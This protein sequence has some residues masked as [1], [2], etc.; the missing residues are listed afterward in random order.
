MD[1]GATAVAATHSTARHE[2]LHAYQMAEDAFAIGNL[3]ESVKF[4][5]QALQQAPTFAPAH[6]LLS[7]IAFSGQLRLAVR[8]LL[9]AS[10]HATRQPAT[11]IA[12]I[13]LRLI[14][15][16]E[17]GAAL[18][19]INDMDT[20]SIQE[21]SVLF[22][23]A[24]QL[25]LLEQHGVALQFL[26]E[27]ESR[28]GETFLTA[29]FRGNAMKFMGRMD[30]AER[31]F[32]RSIALK[33]E[34]CHSH[35]ALAFLGRVAGAARRANRIQALITGG[36]P[37]DADRCY[38]EYAQYREL[39]MLGDDVAAWNSLE[40]GFRSKRRTIRHDVATETKLLT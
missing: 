6:L 3:S 14:S 20:A 18:K 21:S 8:D 10:E 4:A 38:L 22:D 24:Q 23:L 1:L 7:T 31:A 32:E 16:G 33:S 30:D 19:T 11:L 28:G 12:A 27:V 13:A 34:Y 26:E 36:V 37:T 29:Y 40:H 2:V 15:L 35:W 17:T 5:R 9:R 25:T 39:E